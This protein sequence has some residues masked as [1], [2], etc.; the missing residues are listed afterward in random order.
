MPNLDIENQMS[1]LQ[2]FEKLVND[3]KLTNFNYVLDEILA[4]RS[5]GQLYL[6]HDTHWNNLGAYI[7]IQ[8]VYESLGLPYIDVEYL[9]YNPF[10]VSGGD[11]ITMGNLTTQN[12]SDTQYTVNYSGYN[13]TYGLDP[14]VEKVYYIGDS[15][16]N[17]SLQYVEKDYTVVTDHHKTMAEDPLS[18]VEKVQESDIIIVSCVERAF[19]W[20]MG[21]FDKMITALG[22]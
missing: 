4:K 6:K 12:Y 16:R 13:K 7:G 14:N 2:Y 18:C 8:S 9:P 15:Y 10:S 11:L 5:I 20:C 22:Y 1:M 3:A 21:N 17:A 19:S